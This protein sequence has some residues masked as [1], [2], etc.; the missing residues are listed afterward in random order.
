MVDDVLKGLSC[1][2]GRGT[3][4]LAVYFAQAFGPDVRLCD[5][6]DFGEDIPIWAQSE[7]VELVALSSDGNH[8]V[9]DHSL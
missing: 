2:A 5:V 1:T 9:V 3:E 8:H 7:G 6:F 4:F